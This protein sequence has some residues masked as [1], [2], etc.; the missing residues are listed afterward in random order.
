MRR[1]I[2]ISLNGNAFQLEQGGY[3]ALTAYLATAETRLAGNPD[4][5]EILADLEQAIA[6]KCGRYLNPHK[7]V[8]TADEIA[9]AIR[10][11]GPVDGSSGAHSE[12]PGD[13][14]Q[15]AA[16]AGEESAAKGP[17]A[18]RRLYQIREGAMISGVCNGIAAYFDADVTV[19]RVIFVLLAI[20]T[21]G[22]WALAYIVMMFVIPYAETSE[23]HAAA[24]GWPFNAEELIGR[25]RQNYARFSDA[26]QWRR[27]LR[28]A[29]RYERYQQREWRRR[30]RYTR[31][32]QSW[33][34][35]PR[36][37]PPWTSP[38][39]DPGYA[40]NIL[41]G[42]LMTVVGIFSAAL[43]VTM[44]LAVISLVMRHAVLGWTLPAHMPVWVGIVFL[45]VLY[46]VV[47]SP[48]HVSHRVAVSGP[49]GPGGFALWA[50][51]S[52]M[53]FLLLVAWLASQHWAQ[54]RDLLEHLP[55]SLQGAGSVSGPGPPGASI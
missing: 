49:F 9:Q 46:F 54:V 3:E 8:V 51:L 37:P 18:R 33:Q 13:T 26:R 19:V 1:V 41:G 21:W 17:A 2:T 34:T 32:W 10:E 29:R 39:G 14:A 30:W 45:L 20:I 4:K 12:A 7:N 48:L 23:Q 52:W 35:P 28:A 24:H 42:M 47:A 55:A 22:L 50:A 25:A 16:G 44:I 5:A 36:E 40:A 15:R 43:F 53:V 31:Y 6:E 38:P 11:M 27:Q